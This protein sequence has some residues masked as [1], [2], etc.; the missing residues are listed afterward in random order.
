[1]PQWVKR[2]SFQALFTLDTLPK[3]A[4][5]AAKGCSTWVH[6]L[7]QP[8]LRNDSKYVLTNDSKYVLTNDNEY[9]LTND[10]KYVL[11]NNREYVQSG[12]EESKKAKLH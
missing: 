7:N 11:T 1:M 4:K 9:V 6:W 10:S 2:N 8:V 12:E 3:A 5:H